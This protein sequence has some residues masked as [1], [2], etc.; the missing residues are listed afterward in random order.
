[1]GISSTKSYNILGFIRFLQG[2]YMLA[3]TE[4]ECVAKINCTLKPYKFILANKIYKVNFVSY[5]PLFDQS[6]S[7]EVNDLEKT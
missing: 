5:I 6:P 7:N 1:M 2:Y 3:V 4:A